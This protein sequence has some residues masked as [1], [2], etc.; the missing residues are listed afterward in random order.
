MEDPSVPIKRLNKMSEAQAVREMEAVGLTLR[1]N[2]DNLPWQH[3]MIFV[4]P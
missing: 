4:K 1:E 2:I 3:C